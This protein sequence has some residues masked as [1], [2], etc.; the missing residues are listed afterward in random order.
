MCR[1]SIAELIKNRSEK[2]LQLVGFCLR[3]IK[4]LSSELAVPTGAFVALPNF[5]G[6]F[7][8]TRHEVRAVRQC[9]RAWPSPFAPQSSSISFAEGAPAV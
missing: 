8:E 5:F 4:K 3:A 1:G 2:T 7:R 6:Q 9:T